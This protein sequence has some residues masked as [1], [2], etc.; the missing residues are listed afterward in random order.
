MTSVS[1]KKRVRAGSGSGSCLAASV[2]VA[3]SARHAINMF[4]I[5]KFLSNDASWSKFQ[6]PL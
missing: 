3:V 2:A 1:S 5:F 6:F 4:V